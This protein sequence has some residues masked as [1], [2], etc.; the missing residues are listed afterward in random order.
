MIRVQVNLPD[1][2]SVGQV[3]ETMPRKDDLVVVGDDM[4]AF[5][6]HIM[7]IGDTKGNLR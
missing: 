5:A 6:A 7:V 1:S 3:Y 2:S 4:V